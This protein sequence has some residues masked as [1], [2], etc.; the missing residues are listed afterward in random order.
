MAG[1][2]LTAL[3][4]EN[5]FVPA[6]SSSSLEENTQPAQIEM[7][8][9]KDRTAAK[10]LH[11]NDLTK[12]VPETDRRTRSVS[13]GYLAFVIPMNS[14]DIALVKLIRNRGSN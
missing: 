5:K 11:L 8:S 1:E 6:L 3:F 12:N 14:N 13:S 4:A 7:G 10:G 9:P 2:R